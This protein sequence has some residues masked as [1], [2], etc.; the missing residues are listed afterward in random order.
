MCLSTVILDS[1]RGMEEVMQDVARME[2][3][4]DGFLLFGL[5]GEEKF[6]SGKLKSVDFVEE[7]K[8][9]LERS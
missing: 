6:V 3:R 4:G 5:L 7:H 9:V 8:V 1:G 2:A